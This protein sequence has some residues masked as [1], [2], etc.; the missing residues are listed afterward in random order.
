MKDP[1]NVADRKF[2]IRQ[3]G[4]NTGVCQTFLRF[5]SGLIY[6]Y[7]NI[8]CEKNC[9]VKKLNTFFTAVISCMHAKYDSHKTHFTIILVL[10]CTQ[11]VWV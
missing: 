6:H 11:N 9:Q 3:N 8:T 4:E 1:R 10:P 5:L 7:E 2:C